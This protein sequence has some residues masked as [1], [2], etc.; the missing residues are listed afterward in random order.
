MQHTTHEAREADRRILELVSELKVSS[1]HDRLHTD[2]V[3]TFAG[4]LMASHGGDPLVITLAVRLHDLGRVDVSKHG[5]ESVAESCH[6]AQMLLD[7]IGVDDATAHSI[8]EAIADHDDA[9]KAPRSLE[10][11]ILKEADFLAGFGAWGILRTCLWAGESGE[12]IPG[13]VRRLSRGMPARVESLRFPESRRYADEQSSD[14]RF[15]L[16]SLDMPPDFQKHAH[17]G[18][19]IVFEGISGAGKGEQ[20]RLLGDRLAALG[21][22]ITFVS[23]PPVRPST[24]RRAWAALGNRTEDDVSNDELAFLL[25]ATRA[26][27]LRQDLLPALARGAVVLSSRSYI[28]TLVYQ[29][30]E[31]LGTEF[32]AF[33]HRFVPPFDKLLLLDVVPDEA[34]RRIVKRAERTRTELGEFEDLRH[35][36]KHRLAYIDVCQRFVPPARVEVIPP[37]DKQETAER[38]WNSV[39]PLVC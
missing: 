26:R 2:R 35:L 17:E 1:S 28:S 7:E 22:E 10:G 6:A 20:I 31:I 13:A 3:L 14:V 24:I 33:C 5:Q 29:E 34:R 15:F 30:T 19:Y 25:L 36:E 38:V 16:Q 18:V 23:E 21:R 39:K 11:E 32:V 37:G 12:G 8:V 9:S 27:L 4:E